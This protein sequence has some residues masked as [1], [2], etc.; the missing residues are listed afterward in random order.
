MGEAASRTWRGMMPA[1][2]DG[3]EEGRTAEL[4]ERWSPQA[5]LEGSGSFVAD[6]ADPVEHLGEYDES[7]E[8]LQGDFLPV[9]VGRRPGREKWFTVVDGRGRIAWDVK[10]Q[11]EYDVLVLVSRATPAA[12]L[13]YLRRERIAYLVAG[14]DKVDLDAAL[15]KMYDVLEVTCVVST[16]GGGLNGELLRAGLVDEIHLVISPAIIGGLG[17]PTAFDGPELPAGQ[18]PTPVRL[19]ST[20]I[21]KDGL[22]WLGYE[23]VRKETSGA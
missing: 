8:E 10:S 15:R 12:H 7:I 22:I 4:A 5:V 3:V 14:E 16:A 21:E 2:A 13:A 18:A 11:G 23:V 9:E 1:S 6:S 19:L 20:H 17:T